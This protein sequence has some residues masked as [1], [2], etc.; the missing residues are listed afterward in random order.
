[1]LTAVRKAILVLA[2]AIVSSSAMAEWIE[3]GS[4]ETDTLYVDLSTRREKGNLA[5][6]WALND[7]K[8]IQ[9]LEDREPFMSEKTEYEHD[10]EGAQSRLLYL[11]SYTKPMAAGEV[12]GYNLAP[13]EW[14]QFPPESA[15]DI[16]WRIACGKV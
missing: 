4:N 15:L 6:M 7:F 9:R 13:G 5:K 10:C 8:A 14:M 16:L 12:V 3:V 2:L 1:M 11:T